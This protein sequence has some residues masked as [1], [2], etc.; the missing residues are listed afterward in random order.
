MG[1]SDCLRPE[2]FASLDSQRM[3]RQW[4]NSLAASAVRYS[5]AR[6]HAAILGIILWGGFAIV[7]FGSKG[8]RNLVDHLK[9]EDFV[10]VYALAHS[11]FEGPYPTFRSQETFHQ[12]QVQL[13]PA[14]RDDRY[15]PIY[16]P[17]A[18]LIFWPLAQLPY[19]LAALSWALMT[20]ATYGLIIWGAHYPARRLLPDTRFVA[21]AAAAFPP[22]FL[23]VLYGQMTIIPMLG[24]HL[25][26]LGLRSSRPIAA[27]AALGLLTLK[28]QFGVVLLPLFL[29]SRSWQVLLGFVFCVFAQLVAIAWT[30]G[31]Q[32]FTAYG[33]T[34]AGMPSVEY[35][36]EPDAW[37]MHSLRTLTR[38]IPA[39]SGE[40][41]WAVLSLGVIVFAWRLWRSSA[42]LDARFGAMMLATVIVNPHLFAYDAV[43]LAPAFIWLGGWIEAT[44]P[45]V[46]L[47]YWQGVY[48]ISVTLLMPTAAV[49]Y[50]QFSVVLIAWLFWRIGRELLQAQR[51]DPLI[52]EGAR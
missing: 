8:D 13:V 50:V 30:M 11:A 42:A 26:W 16:P 25:C 20:M 29:L 52:C 35:L 12:R 31:S 48:L 27:G 4:R 46:R 10:Q 28:P 44:R 38:I 19:R 37:R 47:A 33:A 22:F 39:P 15:L 9:G 32:A 36:L 24:F 18:A 51:A 1:A 6:V 14:S 23:L 49:I 17:S 40:V 45:S 41:V 43:V 5:E 2:R 34:L 7:T 3:I 21:L